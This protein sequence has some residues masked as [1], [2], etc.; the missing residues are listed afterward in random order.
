MQRG[1][2][3]FTVQVLPQ[4]GSGFFYA[5]RLR[6]DGGAQPFL[7]A[8]RLRGKHGSLALVCLRK[9]KGARRRFLCCRFAL[10]GGI[11][12]GRRKYI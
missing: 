3:V 5:R 9:R 6:S 1:A 8:R 7:Y 4:K 11:T 10:Q 2:A 12:G